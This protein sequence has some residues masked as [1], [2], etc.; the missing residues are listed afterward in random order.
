MGN[1][2]AT[3]NKQMLCQPNHHQTIGSHKL[4]VKILQPKETNVRMGRCSYDYKQFFCLF[5]FSFLCWSSI[6]VVIYKLH[7]IAFEN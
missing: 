5:G 7:F 6:Y 2:D 3:I 1:K 4:S